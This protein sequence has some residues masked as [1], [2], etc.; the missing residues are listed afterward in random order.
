MGTATTR[1]ALGFFLLTGALSAQEGP[2]GHWT[3]SIDI[4]GQRLDVE[5]DLD[6][7]TS[8][9]IGSITIP[10]Q[11]AVGIPLEAISFSNGNCTFR[12]KGAPGEPTFAGTLAADGKTLPGTFTQGGQ[13]FTF[14]LTRTG[15]AK[16]EEAKPNPPVS[17]E[18]VGTWEGAI[19]VGKQLHLILKLTND[20]GNANA[21]I[22]SVDQ[23][24]SE[25]PVATIE[26]KDENLKLVVTAVGAEFRGQ[27]NK[28]GTAIKGT[29][30]QGVNELPLTFT[31]Q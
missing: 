24:G 8:G 4:P 25:F 11:H 9:W 6:K 1:I 20:G 19:D 15:D 14:K 23:A 2:P 30:E 28:A 13:S 27:I 16:V 7:N 18:F 17:K 3:G 31:K 5:V 12:V 10:A 26:Q 22:V 21:V 29:W